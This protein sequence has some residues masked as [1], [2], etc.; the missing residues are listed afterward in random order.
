VFAIRVQE[1]DR[2]MKALMDRGV[3]CGV[4]YPVPIHLQ[5]AY[6]SLGYKPGDF[7]VSEQCANEFLSL[8][9]FPEMTDVQVKHVV[10][11]LGAIM[12]A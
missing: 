3:G 5:P 6:K 11:E 7:P 10:G 9:M 8:P 2:V 4:H 12:Q 1:R